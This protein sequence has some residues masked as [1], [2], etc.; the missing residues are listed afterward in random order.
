MDSVPCHAKHS[1]SNEKRFHRRSLVWLLIIF[2]RRA[3]NPMSCLGINAGVVEAAFRNRCVFTHTNASWRGTQ[4]DEVTSQPPEFYNG[5]PLGRARCSD[6]VVQAPAMLDLQSRHERCDLFLDRSDE[7]VEVCHKLVQ[8][9]TIV[10]VFFAIGIVSFVC[11]VDAFHLN[12]TQLQI[13]CN[14][15]QRRQCQT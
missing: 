4:T 13:S 10:Q 3:L 6:W 9:V 12:F 14:S 11:G 1:F 8:R 5:K 7:K 2:R 15:E